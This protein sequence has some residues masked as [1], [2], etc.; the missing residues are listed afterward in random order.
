MTAV[1]SE[2]RTLPRELGAKRSPRRPTIS[3]WD[4]G[5]ARSIFRALLSN[6]DMKM[7]LK[8]VVL[9]LLV[10]SGLS[11]CKH[12]PMSSGYPPAKL[13]GLIADTDHIVITNRFGDR[14]PRYRGFSLTVSGDEARQIVRA[15][16]HR[17]GALPPIQFLTGACSFIGRRTYWL[18]FNFKVPILCSSVFSVTLCLGGLAHSI[19]VV[20]FYV[21]EGLPNADRILLDVWIAGA[22]LIGGALYLVATRALLTSKPWWSLNSG[23]TFN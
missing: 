22:Q 3:A 11:G 20:H 21:K 9:T 16:R 14:E 17:S 12:P 15:N 2:M 23:P 8:A 6:T 7:M 10:V 4:D 5:T 13:A 1:A 19:G 18:T